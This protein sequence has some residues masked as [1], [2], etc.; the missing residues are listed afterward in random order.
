MASVTA[1]TAK[2]GSEEHTSREGQDRLRV[3]RGWSSCPFSKELSKEHFYEI[4]MYS[5]PEAVHLVQ[6]RYRACWFS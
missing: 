2:A 3:S 4:Y 6:V 5:S 1:L